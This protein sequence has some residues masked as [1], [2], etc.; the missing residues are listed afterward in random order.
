[1][2]VI[3]T[4]VRQDGEARRAKTGHRQHGPWFSQHQELMRMV[5]S[6]DSILAVYLGTE[7]PEPDVGE[8]KVG[9]KL[10]KQSE[11]F[12]FRKKA[13]VVVR[14]WQVTCPSL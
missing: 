9:A 12:L 4:S 11:Q 14:E 6:V 13:L 1:M 3:R 10:P 5:R 8:A 2:Y 7:S